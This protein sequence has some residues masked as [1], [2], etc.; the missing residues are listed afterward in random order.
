M[1]RFDDEVTGVF[2]LHDLD[3][4]AELTGVSRYKVMQAVQLGLLAA[5]Q[6]GSRWMV[7]SEE[8]DRFRRDYRPPT[9]LP[10]L[11]H[12]GRTRRF[13]PP[14]PAATEATG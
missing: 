14:R 6:H 3:E 12:D 8:V 9:T 7:I 10:A 1:I 4:V 5:V 11:D 2:V 13:H